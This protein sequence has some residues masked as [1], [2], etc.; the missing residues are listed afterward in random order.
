MLKIEKSVKKFLEHLQ[1]VKPT[2]E[3]KEVQLTLDE[4]RTILIGYFGLSIQQKVNPSI[5]YL[6]GTNIV[7]QVGKKNLILNFERLKEVLENA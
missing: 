2:E 1:T 4:L 7:R 3:T 6:K 5:I